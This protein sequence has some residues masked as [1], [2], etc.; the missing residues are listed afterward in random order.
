M[1][2]LTRDA[3]RIEPLPNEMA[4][5]RVPQVVKG[6]F[7]QPGSIQ[8]GAARGL[9]EAPSCDVAIVEGRSLGRL[10]DVVVEAG[11]SR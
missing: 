5:V 6:E 7:G 2:H 10:E 4:S 3:D 9:F 11:T 8:T 1:T